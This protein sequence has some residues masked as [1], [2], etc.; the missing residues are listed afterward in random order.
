MHLK[1][2]HHPLVGSSCTSP[3]SLFETQISILDYVTQRPVANTGARE[4]R[5]EDPILVPPNLGTL[6]RYINLEPIA[7]LQ[8]A[9]LALA[10]YLVQMCT[11][12]FARYNILSIFH[13]TLPS[14]SDNV[15]VPLR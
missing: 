12:T 9:A 6:A 7:A 8:P 1:C 11:G 2:S 5:F 10:C 14:I 3:Q 13:V 15:H 4:H